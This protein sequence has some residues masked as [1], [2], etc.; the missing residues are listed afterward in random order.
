MEGAI[1]RFQAAMLKEGDDISN[2]KNKKVSNQRTAASRSLILSK[3]Q[4]TSSSFHARA[5]AQKPD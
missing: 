4:S 1:T 2:V 3:T 5:A